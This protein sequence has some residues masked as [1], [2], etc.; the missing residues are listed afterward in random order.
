M[1][2]LRPTLVSLCL[3][4]LAFVPSAQSA[5][6]SIFE[7]TFYLNSPDITAGFSVQDQ[8][9]PDVGFEN[10]SDV[11]GLALTFSNTLDAQNLGTI[12]VQVLNHTGSPITNAQFFGFLDADIGQ[13]F[14]NNRGDASGFTPGSGSTDATP[15]SWEIG[16]VASFDIRIDLLLGTLSSTNAVPLQGDVG[17]ALG[18]DLGSVPNGG[19]IL[20]TF[21]LSPTDNGGL[22]QVDNGS[23]ASLYFNGSAQ[24]FNDSPHVVP[25]PTSLALFGTGLV[26]LGY[27]VRQYS[28]NRRHSKNA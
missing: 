2:K 28:Q 3:L 27:R 1:M 10:F 23:G 8:R 24:V 11:P 9:L 7:G 26:G 15:D 25:E 21:G 19:S 17:L 18:F 13:F 22:L 4:A 5:P 16:D 6:I 12:T 20:A 14:D